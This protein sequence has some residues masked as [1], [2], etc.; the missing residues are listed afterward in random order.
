MRRVISRL[1][2]Y[3]NLQKMR[4]RPVKQKTSLSDRG[5]PCFSK[6]LR[7]GLTLLAVLATGCSTLGVG[8]YDQEYFR[9][10]YQNETSGYLES[11]DFKIHYIAEDYR[12]YRIDLPGFGFSNLPADTDIYQAGSPKVITLMDQLLDHFDI[13]AVHLAGNS[14]GGY[15]AWKYTSE[16]PDRVRTLAVLDPAS[17]QQSLP[18][19]LKLASNPVLNRVVPYTLPDVFI[20]LGLGQVYG[21]TDRLDPYHRQRY[22]DLTMREGNRRNLARVVVALKES[23]LNPD[24]S[25]G[26]ST[27]K[28][29]VLV[30]WGGKDKWVP[31]KFAKRMQKDIPHAAVQIYDDVGHVPME[32]IAERTVVD[33]MAFLQATK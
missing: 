3:C 2:T 27:I 13:E 18:F 32:E 33:Y 28:R 24:L 21:D 30:M 5:Y 16:R 1:S 17:Y 26:L 25:D 20:K 10:T 9:T 6:A 29:P 31:V 15:L 8:H 23:A 11:G 4:A 7:I 19:L 12:V 22:I 14:I